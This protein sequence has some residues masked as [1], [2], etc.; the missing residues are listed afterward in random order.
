[1]KQVI[2]LIGLCVA[3]SS[4][5]ACGRSAVNT[6]R[7]L[8]LNVDM[9]PPSKIISL[10]NSSMAL[11]KNCEDATKRKVVFLLSPAL[12][13]KR[14]AITTVRSASLIARFCDEGQPLCA[15][16]AT[17]ILGSALSPDQSTSVDLTVIGALVDVVRINP[18]REVKNSAMDWLADVVSDGAH[19]SA[20]SQS[21]QTALETV[22]AVE[23]L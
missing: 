21:A 13:L 6:V 19:T 7:T 1:M 23:A 5:W 4:S 22:A 3:T 2:V 18:T 8:M 14:V 12:S 9:Q 20:T 15:S 16:G 10:V 17:E 11:T